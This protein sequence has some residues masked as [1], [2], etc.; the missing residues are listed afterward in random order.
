MVFT[1][2]SHHPVAGTKA[3]RDAVKPPP[4]ISAAFQL[5]RAIT[6]GALLPLVGAH[7]QSPRPAA[8][9]IAA[10][11]DAAPS[12]DWGHALTA[13]ADI[14]CDGRTALVAVARG[15]DTVW[16]GVLAGGVGPS[17]A[18]PAM[19]HWPI[20]A[21]HQGGFCAAPVRITL[22]PHDCDSAGGKLP[23]CKADKLCHDVS[24]EDDFCDSF[25]VFWDSSHQAL[26]WWRA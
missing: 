12:A 26:N 22:T 8:P 9:E 6:L 1:F 15:Q 18:K 21:A 23:G 24:L 13:R 17:P 25:H 2:A 5:M 16:L 14:M 4:V 7:A 10:L 11:H 3:L 20:D 19:L